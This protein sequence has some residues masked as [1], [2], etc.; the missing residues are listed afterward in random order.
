M[1]SYV[2]AEAL[3]MSTHNVH[4][5][6]H[7]E[8]KKIVHIWIP[9]LIWSFVSKQKKTKKKKLRIYFL[10]GDM[11]QT[12]YVVQKWASVQINALIK[13]KYK[14]FSSTKYLRALQ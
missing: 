9:P 3:L 6:F 13:G 2:T 7:G 5:C 14:G 12:S 8:V 10:S 11:E 4:V 1:K